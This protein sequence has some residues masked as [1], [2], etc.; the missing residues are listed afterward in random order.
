MTKQNLTLRNMFT[1]S[2]FALYL[3]F[4]AYTLI[5]V[6]NRY[7]ERGDKSYIF[8][9]IALALISAAAMALFR[10][11]IRI[12]LTDRNLN[13]CFFIVLSITLIFM[14][15]IIFT[16]KTKP[17]ADAKVLDGAARNFAKDGNWLNIY[18][19]FAKNQGYFERYT[20]NWS[21]LI[22]LSVYFRVFYLILGYVPITAPL[23]LNVLFMGISFVFYYF[24]SRL[25]FKD[26]FK[27]LMSIFAMM[28]CLP[29]YGHVNH[30]YTDVLSLPFVMSSVYFVIRTVKSK[31]VKSFLINLIAS[32]IIVAVGY[33]FKGS[34]AVIIVSSII[35][36]FIACGWKKSLVSIFSFLTIFLLVNNVLLFKFVSANNIITDDFEKN[37][38][39]AT[40]WIMMGLKGKGC[41]SQK[42]LSFTYHQE[43]Y[44]ERKEANIKIIK[45]RLSQSKELFSHFNTKSAFTWSDGKYRYRHYLKRANDSPLKAF[46][47]KSKIS[48]GYAQIYHL[49]ML[50]SMFVCIIYS[51]IRK[52]KSYMLYVC[53]SVFGLSLFLM[54]WETTPRYLF[55]FILLFLLMAVD[56]FSHLY[57]F[58]YRFI[59][60]NNHC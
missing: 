29:L 16:L 19:G 52:N 10:S 2:I 28:F 26:R 9:S 14:L 6:I 44:D 43:N 8:I 21:L 18:R 17:N 59:R 31:S 39:P 51:L 15:Y 40:H 60:K 13:V 3:L 54:I 55:N 12:H 41:F 50:L 7:S 27:I 47:L 38:F 1:I 45:E 58:I 23:L 36:I 34:L 53:L 37:R 25:I 42:E 48:H 30:T 4:F 22:L 5:N 32:S 57:K 49:I 11:K 20:N 24:I 35:Y 33:S 46:L 56:G